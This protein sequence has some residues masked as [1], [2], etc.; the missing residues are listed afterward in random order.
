M[1]NVL[2]KVFN[3]NIGKSKI[4]NEVSFAAEERKRSPD[5][6]YKIYINKFVVT[7]E[8]YEKYDGHRINQ[9]RIFNLTL[10]DYDRYLD[11]LLAEKHKIIISLEK[12]CF[13]RSIDLANRDS[14]SP[15]WSNR[16]F[17]DIYND[18]CYK[19]SGNLQKNLVYDNVSYDLIEDMIK[20]NFNFKG[21]LNMTGKDMCPKLYEDYNA[22]LEE[23][24]KVSFT[25]KV[26]ALYKCNRCHKSA[27][28]IENVTLRS[29]DEGTDLEITCMN[30]NKKW[31]A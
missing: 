3:I 14:I 10:E 12:V 6:L 8:I 5:E 1:D 26:S 30:C 29:A 18:I 25:K 4:K 9:M 19:I 23:S 16:L 21:I 22:K 2:A 13:N 17:V 15:T 20:P 24:K 28:I 11:L 27:C 7:N 31:N